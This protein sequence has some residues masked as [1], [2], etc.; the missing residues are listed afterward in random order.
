MMNFHSYTCLGADLDADKGRSLINVHVAEIRL[1]RLNHA[2][3]FFFGTKTIQ[4]NKF[5]NTQF[6]STK[7]YKMLSQ[8]FQTRLKL[9]RRQLAVS[10]KTFQSNLLSWSLQF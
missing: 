3:V 9:I 1:Y 8:V 7:R 10:N 2:Q 6:E 5:Q 4:N